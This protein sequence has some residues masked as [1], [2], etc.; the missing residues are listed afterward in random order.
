MRGRNGNAYAA[1]IAGKVAPFR[2]LAANVANHHA[3]SKRRAPCA[4]AI[5]RISLP[6]LGTSQLGA[7]EVVLLGLLINVSI[8]PHLSRFP[9]SLGHRSF[10]RWTCRDWEMRPRRARRLT[11]L[12][13]QHLYLLYQ[14]HPYPCRR[15]RTSIISIRHPRDRLPNACA[16]SH[17]NR[18]NRNIHP[19]S[20]MNI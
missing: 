5:Q 2:L 16:N 8:L 6:N 7:L 12:L 13:R 1:I 4:I 19:V 11:L 18:R 17:R 15:L 9:L 20:V 14:L 10:H 3:G